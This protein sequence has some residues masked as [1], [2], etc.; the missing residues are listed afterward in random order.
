MA[1]TPGA[2]RLAALASSPP[3][4]PPGYL[5][6]YFKNDGILYIKDSNNLETPIGVAA[7]LTGLSG[8][9]TATGPG[10]ASA[11]VAF[12]GGKT[13]AEI[14]ASVDMT[15]GATSI[16]APNT[17]VERDGSGNFAANIITAALNG[18]ASGNVAKAGDTMS[19]DLNMGGNQIRNMASPSISGDATNKGYVDA[20][21]N[22][23]FDKAGGTITGAVAIT[24]TSGVALV[25]D[26]NVFV[27]DAANNKVGINKLNPTEALDVIG[28]GLFSGTIIASNLSGSNTG[29]VTIL[30]TNSINLTLIGQQLQA[31]VRYADSTIDETASG[32]R[33]APLSL[34]NAQI[35]LAAGIAYS[36]LNLSNSITN[37]DIAAAAAI[38]YSK[39]N[40]ANSILNS[41]ISPTAAIAYSKLNLLGSITDSDIALSAAILRS[42]LASG[43]NWRVLINNGSG[44]MSEAAAITANRAL[45]S[46]SNG[47]PTHSTVTNTEL[48]Y[49]SGTTSN[50]Q[51]QIDTIN[52]SIITNEF[53]V[54]KNGNDTTGTG[55]KLRPFQTVQ[56]AVNAVGSATST[57]DYEDPA[58]RFWAI[59]IMNGVYTENVTVGTRMIIVFDFNSAQ[60]VGNVTINF[61]KGIAALATTRQPKY[62]FKD[63]DLRPSFTGAGI[64]LSG[65]N[66]NINW[67]W[68][69]GGSSVIAQVHLI[70]TGVSGNISTALGSGGTGN[71]VLQVIGTESYITGQVQITT[72]SGSGQVLFDS[73]GDDSVGLGGATGACRL[74][75]LRNVRF[76]GVV[77]VSGSQANS[78]W[79][80]TS[81]VTGSS[82]SGS[83]GLISA[84][85][86]S[87]ESY[88][89]NVTTKGS[90]T[91]TFIDNARGTAYSPTTP[92]D[93]SPTPNNVRTALDQTRSLL[94]THASRH[95]PN[96]ADP[97][98]TG[99]PITLGANST[100]DPGT[101]NTLVRSD[102][103]HDLATGAPSQ[104]NADGTNTEGT[105]NNLARADHKHDIATGAPVTI[106]T[107]NSA[108]TSSSVA[109]ADHVHAHGNQTDPNLHAVATPTDNGFM[110][111]A[112][113]AKLDAA[114]N[115]NNASSIVRR[116]ANGDFSAGIITATFLGTINGVDAANHGLRHRPGG[117]DAI[118]T[119][120]ASNLIPDQPSAEGTS[121]NLARADHYH[122]IP[123]GP[124]SQI[125]TANFAGAASSFALSDHV[126]NH[127]NQN[128]PNHHAV[129]TGLANGF[130]SAADKQKLDDATNL[131]NANSI[132]RRDA[133]GNFSANIITGTLNGSSTNFSGSLAGDVSGTQGATVV[134]QVG[135]KTAA[136]IATS[137]NDTQ[138]ATDLNTP[139]RIVERDA[140]GNFSAG[141]VSQSVARLRGATNN[142]DLSANPSADYSLV[143]PPTQGLAGTYLTNDGL[144]NLTWSSPQIN[145]DGGRPDTIF[146]LNATINGGTP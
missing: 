71:G 53:Y 35:A 82:M 145:I 73:M 3:A 52:G 54:D 10:I 115:L 40:L 16:N 120:T 106:G 108:G 134:N 129:A 102:H 92:A 127:G 132:V 107:A 59:R 140:S 47:I 32:I 125:G 74:L 143:M 6:F 117:P 121:N 60:L 70:H 144:G 39:L 44:V 80:N 66:G 13:A 89:N 95:L 123:S 122:N 77:N 133:S 48:S 25:V 20:A 100:N 64:P 116:D 136:E 15:Q 12:V 126:H 21:D 138:A 141:R 84:D 24:D 33:V 68:I 65:V 111:A 139:L 131:N 29:D 79:Y 30:D 75:M 38:A 58:K 26:G 76:S 78:Q 93:W 101:A 128:N 88:F 113:K 96:G 72:G 69:N 55:S 104:I 99:T 110:S 137:V 142:V 109:R 43:S 118:P 11:V 9:V 19:G 42:K 63:S 114:T 56:R 61:D 57:A 7:G 97:I 34:T 130:M 51:S 67:N 27:V 85:S 87:Y 86:N 18:L 37:S 22:L 124:V 49:L 45:I 8:D 90:E 146:V 103:S 105:S 112:D 5:I 50:I 41:D 31:A 81:F 98:A 94:N 28:N 23:K 119:G 1:L 91:F 46:D 83:S 14:A 4:P 62:V 17:L 135:G 36:K 2:G